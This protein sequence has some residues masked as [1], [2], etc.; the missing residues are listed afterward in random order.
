MRLIHRNIHAKDEYVSM[1]RAIGYVYLFKK[2]IVCNWHTQLG[3]RG[4]NSSG[5]IKSYE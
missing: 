2:K 5:Y 3:V 1:D 4:A